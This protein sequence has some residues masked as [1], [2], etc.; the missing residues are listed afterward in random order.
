M[1]AIAADIVKRY[2]VE[3]PSAS[4]PDEWPAPESLVESLPD[5]AQFD[6]DLMPESLRPL[7]KDVAERMQ[8]PLD[9][10]AVAAIATLAG[11]TN[12]RACIQPKRNDHTDGRAEPLGRY[13]SAAWDARI[14]VL[15]ASRNRRV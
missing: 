6:L 14:P 5:V 13:R 11:V 15:S 1:R 9:F 10:P 7:V 8:V 3:E 2:P 12:R 4:L